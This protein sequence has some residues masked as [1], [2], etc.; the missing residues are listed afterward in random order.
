PI[1]QDRNL[2]HAGLRS[3][4]S[5]VNGIHNNKAGVTFQHTFLNANDSLGIVD[6]NLL[7]T[8][9]DA[10][11]NPCFDASTNVAAPGTPCATLLPIDLTRGGARFTFGGHADIKELSLYLQ[12]TISK[13]NW[14]FNLG[15]RGDIYRGLS[16]A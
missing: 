10:N 8:T 11:G 15:L 5:Y 14:S 12:D 6:P 2:T 4:I 3:D 13:G 1:R 16:S 7:P 9:T